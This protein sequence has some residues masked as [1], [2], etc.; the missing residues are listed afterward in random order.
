MWRALRSF[1]RPQLPSFLAWE[2][3]I[4]RA[5]VLWCSFPAIHQPVPYD[6]QPAPV[7]V[8]QFCDLTWLHTATWIQPLVIAAACLY[9]LGI[10]PLLSTGILFTVQVLISTLANS[11][12]GG[13][14]AHHTTNIIAL[15]L[16]A[17]CLGICYHYFKVARQ[18]G[19]IGITESMV[20]QFHWLGHL[21]RQPSAAARPLPD[22]PVEK[23]AASLRFHQIWT[24]WQVLAASYTV[25]GISKLIRSEGR[26]VQEIIHLPLQFEKNRLN[27]IADTA[28]PNAGAAG[29]EL[30]E[31]AA[32]LIAAHPTAAGAVFSL[33]LF[34]ELCAFLA[35][36]NRRMATLFGLGL[37][38][39]HT[40]ISALMNLG[41]YYN[42][43]LL[44]FLWVGLPWWLWQ[45]SR[46]LRPR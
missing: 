34:L 30:G 2:W 44:F 5:G 41:F 8:A 24:M 9:S 46:H 36:W 13:G 12:G 43:A 19:L 10:F 32:A 20:L 7:G 29:L 22:Q 35:L 25:S 18:R 15:I 21:I 3:W 42:K 11:Q 33:G 37:I 17:Q 23:L 31:R 4:M 40:G 1:L 28:D 26:W 45:A 38:L 27:R 6:Q 39:M 14:G 16:G